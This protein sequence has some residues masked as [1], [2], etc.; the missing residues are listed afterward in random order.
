MPLQSLLVSQS[1]FAPAPRHLFLLVELR[2]VRQDRYCP[3]S[4]VNVLSVH[5]IIDQSLELLVDIDILVELELY[6]YPFVASPNLIEPVAV[7]AETSKYFL[8]SS[9][10]SASVGTP[11]SFSVV[12]KST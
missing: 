10:I 1:Q 4:N 5:A 3:A 2:S 9:S 7:P 6:K 11:S 8:E 12:Q